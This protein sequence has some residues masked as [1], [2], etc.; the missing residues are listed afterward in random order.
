MKK[1]IKF[2][3]ETNDKTMMLFRKYSS[4][5]TNEN[6]KYI[7]EI[8]RGMN[9]KGEEIIFEP[10]Y[11]KLYYK[12]FAMALDMLENQMNKKEV[13]LNITFDD[14]NELNENEKKIIY[15]YLQF[16]ILVKNSIQVFFT[17]LNPTKVE[18][19]LMGRFTFLEMESLDDY[20]ILSKSL[21]VEISSGELKIEN[22]SNEIIL[23]GFEYDLYGNDLNTKEVKEDTIANENTQIIKPFS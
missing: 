5:T 13:K 12:F 10:E 15:L 21:K 22:R 4:S 19:L 7:I 11:E 17:F 6:I 3:P 18:S 2:L 20:K 23:T 8:M 1:K 14:L 9:I 16:S